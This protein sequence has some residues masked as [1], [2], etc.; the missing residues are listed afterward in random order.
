[1]RREHA[2]ATMFNSEAEFQE[3]GRVFAEA[4]ETL[5]ELG[6]QLGLAEAYRWQG[7]WFGREGRTAERHAAYERALAAAEASGNRLMRR[8][9]ME[10]VAYALYQG[11]A[12]VD[13]AIRRCEEMIHSNDGDR[14][15]EAGIGR[16]MAA[17]VAMAGRAEEAVELHERSLRVLDEMNITGTPVPWRYA[18][19][20]TREYAGDR[21][22]AI[23]ELTWRPLKVSALAMVASYWRALLYCDEGRWDKAERRL[24]HGAQVP[25]PTR[26]RPEAPLRLAAEARIAAH[27]GR[28]AEALTLAHRAVELA[29]LSDMLNLRGRV[30]AASAEVGESAGE[31]AAADAALAR[32]LQLYEQKGN[33]A[34]AAALRATANA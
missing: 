28:S 7:A 5:S 1:M 34:A 25:V 26:F 4:I 30:W 18:A 9:V 21:A 16:F 32:A 31:G 3:A 20:E 11:P 19:A 24:A 22:G 12:P 13:E 17:L 2:A 33:V 6:D 23:R 10:A 27:H 14:A 29:D 8:N 15:L